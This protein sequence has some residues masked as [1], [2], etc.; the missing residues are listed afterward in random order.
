[1]KNFLLSI[2]VSLLIIAPNAQAKEN[3]YDFSDVYQISFTDKAKGVVSSKAFTYGVIGASAIVGVVA[4][5]ITAGAGAPAVATGMS[6]IA[7]WAGGSGAGSYMAG[8]STIGGVFGGNAITGAAVLNGVA[9]S[10]GITATG[11][12]ALMPVASKLILATTVTATAL[13]GVMVIK[14]HDSGNIQFITNL[15]LPTSDKLGDEIH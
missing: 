15:Q 14:E 11:K 1:M 12:L 4:T 7:T 2:V 8:L 9:W 3:S 10:A 6:S 5:Y 13:D